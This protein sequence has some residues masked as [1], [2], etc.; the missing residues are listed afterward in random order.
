MRWTGWI[1]FVFALH[2]AWEMA[3]ARWFASMANLPFWTATLLCLR[4]TLGDL[5]ITL[6]SFFVA[7]AM[8][9]SV[10]WPVRNFSAGR[11]LVYVAVGLAITIVIEIIALRTDRWS[12]ADNMPTLFGIGVL[13]LAQWVI[14]PLVALAVFRLIWSVGDRP[15]I[16]DR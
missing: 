13:P 2:F 3:Q 8:A 11:V 10:E 9:R 7:A 16:T 4:A 12:Y 6:V 15:L 14:L 1:I 5:A